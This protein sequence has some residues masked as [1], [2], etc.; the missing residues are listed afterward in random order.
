MSSL[1]KRS[2][3]ILDGKEIGKLQGMGWPLR[4]EAWA[5]AVRGVHASSLCAG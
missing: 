3:L 2:A 4:T 5:R 1:R